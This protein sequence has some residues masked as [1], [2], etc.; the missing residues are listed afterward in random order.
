MKNER[1]VWLDLLRGVCIIAVVVCHQQGSLHSSE[2]V[3][4]LTLYSVTGFIFAMGFTKGLSL[5]SYIQ[6]ES[7]RQTSFLAYSIKSMLKT[8][9]AYSFATI[10][11]LEL[12]GTTDFVELFHRL[13]SFDAQSLYY[14][15]KYY[16]ILSL[17]APVLYYIVLFA[18][19][20]EGCIKGL[21]TI[22][23]I[24][25]IWL[26]G[27]FSV[28]RIN[29]LGES[30]LTVYFIGIYLSVSGMPRV[31]KM[32]T[33]SSALLLLCGGW[34]SWKFYFERVAGNYNY[35]DYID[36]IDSKLQLNPPNLSI[37]LYSF[38]VIFMLYTLCFYVQTYIAKVT[39]IF[40][41]ICVLGRYSL[42]IFLW[43]LFIMNKLNSFDLVLFENIL[44]KRLVYYSL[45]FCLP[46]IGRLIYEENKKRLYL[47]KVYNN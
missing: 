43:H 17:W 29:I 35:K 22:A 41:P 14:F 1:I 20:Y 28:G 16:L 11:I 15:V 25:F 6:K 5:Q 44:I 8:L 18:N 12:N 9:A 13:L 47:F 10:V 3:Q 34:F 21:M 32:S 37:I 24:V 40:Y 38:G 45:M 46:I 42:D 7:T 30:Y 36:I 4:Y 2:V 27:Y 33:T 26:L 23:I 31:N 39:W 19:R